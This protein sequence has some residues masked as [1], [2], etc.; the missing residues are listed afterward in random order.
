MAKGKKGPKGKKITLKIA[1]NSLKITIDGKRRLDLSKM[2]IT[3]FPKCILKMADVDE[4]DL[5]RNMIRKIPES[6]KKFQNLRWLDL[7]SNQID[8]IPES[9]GQLQNLL[10]LNVS[11]N[12]LTNKGL[13]QEICT[14][15]NLRMLNL[16][17]NTLDNIPTTFG[18][19]KEL[20]EVGLFDNYL[21]S[22]PVSIQKLPKLKKLNTLR[23][24]FPQPEEEEP[25]DPIKRLDSLYLVN[26]SD[27]CGS[28]L[29]KSQQQR[30]KMNDI[31]REPAACKRNPLFTNLITPNSTAKENQVEWR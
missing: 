27:L 21:T 23:N 24:P 16:G 12:K 26:E 10:F 11:N 3:T 31:I 17:L 22:I 13:P 18:S 9:I 30:D 5:S 25:K 8:K 14:L 19:L 1:K 29:T 28:C 6:I 15:K 20:K 2:G 7:H 4:L